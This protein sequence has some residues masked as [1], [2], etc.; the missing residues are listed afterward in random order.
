MFKYRLVDQRVPAICLSLA[1]AKLMAE[2][3]SGKAP[4]M[5]VLVTDT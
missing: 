4:T 2:L 5:R 3:P 1:V